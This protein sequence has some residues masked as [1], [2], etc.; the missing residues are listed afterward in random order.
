MSEHQRRIIVYGPK[1]VVRWVEE[2]LAGTPCTPCVVTS[3][4]D[5]IAA[6]LS[7]DPRSPAVLVVDIDVLTPQQRSELAALG[8]HGWYG[9]FVALG[10]VSP[11]LEAAL[12]ITH[13]IRRPLGSEK[14]RSI[15]LALRETR[16]T[17]RM[18]PA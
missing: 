14:L 9:T 1:V 11:G 16:E 6:V 4:S 17:V 18:Q 8:D 13:V 2:E 3:C 5:A 15:C 10:D 12:R 7:A